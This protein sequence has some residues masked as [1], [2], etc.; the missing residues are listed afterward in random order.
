MYF[1]P[2]LCFAYPQAVPKSQKN[3][4]PPRGIETSAACNPSSALTAANLNVTPNN[5][6]QGYSSNN[7]P[8]DTQYAAYPSTSVQKPGYASQHG[9]AARARGRLR[10]H[11]RD[12]L[13]ARS[14]PDDRALHRQRDGDAEPDRRL[15]G[16]LHAR[17]LRRVGAVGQGGRRR[18][19]TSCS[20]S[21][22]TARCTRRRSSSPPRAPSRPS[23]AGARS[24]GA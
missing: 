8:P 19:S 23:R 6:P 17:R 4:V 18:T 12:P 9:P 15:G 22:S 13:R 3:K 7:V 11:R 24:P 16:R 20:A 2:V 21:S 10:R 1:R 5:S 14:G